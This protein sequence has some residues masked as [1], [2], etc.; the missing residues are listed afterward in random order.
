MSALARVRTPIASRTFYPFALAVLPLIWLGAVFA[1]ALRR[2]RSNDAVDS[3]RI[4]LAQADKRLASAKDALSARDARKFHAELASALLGLL[5][6]RLHEPVTGLTHPELRALFARRGLPDPLGMRI[7]TVLSDCDFAR[8][9][10]SAVTEADMQQ[11][12][13]LVENLWPQL[14]AFSPQPLEAA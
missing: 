4:A 8:F 5:A 11:R 1:P 6:A 14:V 7:L 13:A 2:L 3:D 12:L 10:S 9:S